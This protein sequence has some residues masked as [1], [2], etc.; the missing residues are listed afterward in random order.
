MLSKD[1][2]KWYARSPLGIGSG[3]MGLAAVLA[4]SV[5]GLHP[6]LALV[7]GTAI[8]ALAGLA[9]LFFGLGP[10][11]ALAASEAAIARD[12]A[13]HRALAEASR[14]RL[15][16]LR[17]TDGQVAEAASLVVLAAGEYLDACRREA[18]DDPLADAALEESLEIVDIFMKELDE[19][20]TEKRFGLQDKDPFADAEARVTAALKEKALVIRER[21]IQIDGGLPASGRMSV[22][23]EI[24]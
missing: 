21:R 17:I 22:R 7:A 2:L 12:R 10:K 19:K 23:E 3:F 1:Y 11:A 15:S 20:A 8:V 24:E 4:A 5:A 6:G 18:S 16:R 14:D 9:A 13:H